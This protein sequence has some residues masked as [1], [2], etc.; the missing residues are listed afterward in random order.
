MAYAGFW[1][2][3]LR[4]I[5]LQVMLVSEL[6]GFENGK[7]FCEVSASLSGLGEAL[8]LEL[9]IFD[10]GQVWTLRQISA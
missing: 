3:G 6:F 4:L 9:V 2:L 7:A 1:L 10:N 5:R 8:R